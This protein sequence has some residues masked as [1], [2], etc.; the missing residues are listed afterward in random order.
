M[1]A[2]NATLKMQQRSSGEKRNISIK[3]FHTFV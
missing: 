2:Y 3:I 1:E